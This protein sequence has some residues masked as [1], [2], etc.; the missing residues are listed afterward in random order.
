MPLYASSEVQE[1]SF[2][3][4]PTSGNWSLTFGNKNTG[5]LAYN[6]SAAALQTA[7]NGLSSIKGVG[8]SVE[9]V[10][11]QNAWTYFVVFQ[12]TLA[13]ASGDL[14]V[15]STSGL[16]PNKLPLITEVVQGQPNMLPQLVR[17]A[18]TSNPVVVPNSAPILA[19]TPSSLDPAFA[20]DTQQ[21]AGVACD[22]AGDFA[23]TWT[24]TRTLSN[25]SQQQDVYVRRFNAMGG[26]LGVDI[27]GNPIFNL[28]RDAN[29]NTLLD[30]NGNTV[31]APNTVSVPI[32]VNT[33]AAGP[34]KWSTVAMDV[35]GDFVVTWSS[36]GQDAAGGYGIYASASIPQQPRSGM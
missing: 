19:V 12:G 20:G 27:N 7:L 18:A 1:I 4:Q 11:G 6:I 31:F 13:S 26:L 32:Q 9:V 30:A 24:D 16:A 25:G 17:D 8:G 34:Q 36:F 22:A 21:Y 29:G 5:N 2:P 10:N 35:A 23:I 3:A 28:Q 14:L 33:Y 15:A